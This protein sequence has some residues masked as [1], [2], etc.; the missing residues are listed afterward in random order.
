MSTLATVLVKFDA[1]GD[2]LDR[3]FD[4]IGHKATS[5]GSVIGEALAAGAVVATTAIVGFTAKGLQEFTAFDKGMR[6]VF[7][8]L[9][10]ITEEAM[11]QMTQQVKDF[12]TEFGVLPEK[13]IPALYQAISAGVPKDNVFEFLEVAQKAAAGGVT[14]L[15]TAVDGISSVINAYG[16]DVL[17]AAEASDLMFT[18]VRLGKTTFGELAQSLFNVTPIASA[19]G[20]EFG[21][22]TAALA[23]MTAQGV[24][25]SVAT[26][27]LR[28]MFVEL[29]KAG[30]DADQVFR[31]MA[32]KSF[33]EFIGEGHNLQEALAVMAQAADEYGVEMQDLFGSVEA[34]SAALTLTGKGADAFTTALEQ[35]GTSA[36]ATQEAYD[37][38]AGSVQTSLDKLKAA[39]KVLLLTV[40]EEAAPIFQSAVDSIVNN[41]PEIQAAVETAMEKVGAAFSAAR[42]Y[43]GGLIS[44]FMRL[45]ETKGIGAA[46]DGLLST[47]SD[48]FT[49]WLSGGGADAIGAAVSWVVEEAAKKIAD[50]GVGLVKG[51]I[52][53]I[54]G[55][56]I[57]A[58][59]PWQK[60][61]A[62]VAEGIVEGL[63]SAA[64]SIG[65][66]IA[67][68]YLNLVEGPYTADQASV[69]GFQLWE[70]NQDGSYYS[71]EQATIIANAYGLIGEKSALAFTAAFSAGL[72]LGT[73]EFERW[74]Q[75]DLGEAGVKALELIADEHGMAYALDVAR[76]IGDGSVS[77][78]DVIKA[79]FGNTRVPGV[80][81][82]LAGL[83]Y[84]GHLSDYIT[85][86][87]TVEDIEVY[88]RT[89]EGGV[90]GDE[91]GRFFTDEFGNYIPGMPTD[92]DAALREAN[93]D[94]IGGTGGADYDK[95]FVDEINSIGQ[96]INGSM[97]QTNAYGIGVSAGAA[98]KRGVLAGV[99]GTIS[100]GIKATPH[101]ASGGPIPGSGPVP[102]VAHGGEYVLTKGDTG[103]MQKLIAA[104]SGGMQGGS[105]VTFAPG[106]IVI[107]G[108]GREA[109]EA[110]NVI[111]TR[112]NALGVRT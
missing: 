29:S 2:D 34:G 107:N 6:E 36:G 56:D 48:K 8:L 95:A 87:G 59:G 27:Q 76:A 42:E 100:I 53:G 31:D 64:V 35:M 22:V 60:V 19:L 17:S 4:A 65:E 85:T 103:L 13:T 89:V 12:A 104:V 93:A 81:G 43:V 66:S 99:G 79:A 61:G 78:Q 7:T 1:K 44:D 20:V 25:T 70:G 30:G 32:G 91:Q 24:P 82:D 47:L 14:E 88:L 63:L 105:N 21:D 58:N 33:Q 98:F 39:W 45:K 97:S 18:A 106:S 57:Q 111:T 41:M 49:G 108:G 11:G 28:Q 54:L 10:G 38:M 90:I 55:T 62:A 5:I 86:S 80:E 109:Q 69:L 50:L 96:S 40:G 74:I 23:A 102:I 83:T 3:G 52:N 16:K 37:R 73:P 77:I 72:E 68:A 92:I 94:E 9:P 112:I 15:E 51:F 67:K 75:M 46:V 110:M 101:Y 84:A 26:T 71:E